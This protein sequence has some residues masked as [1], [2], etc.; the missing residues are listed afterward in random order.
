MIIFDTIVLSFVI[1]VIIYIIWKRGTKLELEQ[2]L[3]PL[4]TEY[5]N[6]VI[7]GGRAKFL[8]FS[9]Y[10]DFLVIG[11]SRSIIIQTSD[12]KSPNIERYFGIQGLA[13]HHKREDLPKIVLFLRDASKAKYILQG[14]AGA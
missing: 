13:I 10:T 12:I 11:F 9:I 4:F 7:D 14:I 5:C 1:F 6:G 3:D 2:G 8:R